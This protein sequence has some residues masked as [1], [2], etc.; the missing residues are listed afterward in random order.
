MQGAHTNILPV[1]RGRCSAL[2][3]VGE[4]TQLHDVIWPDRGIVCKS[5]VAYKAN[6]ELTSKDWYG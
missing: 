3:S 6:V 1:H 2:E 5:I 4:N